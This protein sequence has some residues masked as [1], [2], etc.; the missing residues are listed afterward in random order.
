MER[1]RGGGGLHNIHGNKQDALQTDEDVYLILNKIVDPKDLH[2]IVETVR[3][4]RIRAPGCEKTARTEERGGTVREN[5]NTGGFGE[6]S[7]EDRVRSQ[8]SDP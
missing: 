5:R 7:V 8:R 2:D 4:G 1:A 6:D 3:G